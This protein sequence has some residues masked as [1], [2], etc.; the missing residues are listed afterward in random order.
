[1]LTRL[2]ALSYNV[3]V[4]R[5]AAKN[6]RGPLGMPETSDLTS[7]HPPTPSPARLIDR[8]VI[9]VLFVC[10]LSLVTYIDRVAMSQAAPFVAHDFNLTPVQVGWVFSAFGIAYALF[11]IPGGWLGDRIGPRPVLTRI[12]LWWTFF[13]AAT[14]WTQ[15][16]ASLLAARF[17]FG[18]GEAG[19]FPNIAK[20]LN[21]WLSPNQRA[22][23]QGIV[24]LC[25][26]WAG[27]FTPILAFLL[28]RVVSWRFAFQVF[29]LVGLVWV[30]CFRTW[31]RDPSKAEVSKQS[32]PLPETLR[33]RAPHSVPWKKLATSNVVLLLWIQYFAVSWGWSFYITWLPTYV[34]Q[35][36]AASIE[37]SAWLSA[38]PL[39]LGGFGCL[40]GGAAVPLLTR[41]MGNRAAARATIA[42]VGCVFSG[43]FL[44]VSLHVHGAFG[45]LAIIG[46]AS[47]FNDLALA[48][49]WDACMD[50]GPYIGSVSGSMNM[51]GNLAGSAA[52]PAIGYLLSM[53]G[54]AWSLVFYLS[55]AFYVVG[56][57]AW[58]VIPHCKQSSLAMAVNNQ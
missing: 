44:V 6:G 25:S 19:C 31:Y 55:A 36:R 47:F 17:L 18:A 12:V 8:R 5:K 3:T 9:A 11:E 13:T 29:A 30:W 53:A 26:R 7:E 45:A 49:A 34:R 15:N 1:V 35:E 22:R 56:A 43:L 4:G 58:L 38:L 51:I 37:Q 32:H 14:G 39:F 48:P 57:L 21:A 20:I 28:I 24:W 16:Y 42:A 40:A 2:A 54:H 23:A 52:P 41:V 50:A 27:A 46:T 33:P 10:T